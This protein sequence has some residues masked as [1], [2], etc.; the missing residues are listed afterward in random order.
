MWKH[1][2]GQK[3]RSKH[4]TLYLGWVPIRTCAQVSPAHCPL[5]LGSPKPCR[6]AWKLGSSLWLAWERLPAR[7]CLRS[8]GKEMRFSLDV[9]SQVAGSLRWAPDFS[10][11]KVSAEYLIISKELLM[12]AS[13]CINPPH[14]QPL[15][16][17][18][19]WPGSSQVW[20]CDRL[21]WPPGFRPIPRVPSAS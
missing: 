13:W 14:P 19:N 17:G 21:T 8:T 10:I 18:H 7:D 3:G 16:K 4:H 6:D 20:S 2:K 5:L 9:P 12:D 1:P 15:I 11:Q